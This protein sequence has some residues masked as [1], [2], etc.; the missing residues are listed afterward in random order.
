MLNDAKNALDNQ[1]YENAAQLFFTVIKTDPQNDLAH[2]GL[3]YALYKSNRLE[4][5]QQYCETAIELNPNLPMPYVILSYIN[6]KKREDFEKCYQLA[7]KAY[8]LAPDLPETLACFG[9][10]SLLL[11]KNEQAVKF[12]QRALSIS[13]SEWEIHNNLSIAYTRLNKFEEA[14][15]ETLVI[16]KLKPSL[17]MGIMLMLSFMAIDRVIK[18]SRVILFGSIFAALLLTS[19][20]LL[21]IPAIYAS[22]ML[23]GG[24]YA[25]MQK[26]TKAGIITI[27]LALVIYL[28]VFLLA[29]WLK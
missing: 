11:N 7:E 18:S 15:R 1:D 24:I 21:L 20:S 29:A 23:V 9:F 28:I 10:T 14:Y 25:L 4:E 27:L 12:L 3:G 8:A 2:Q 22:L 26:S 13:P 5:S 19:S 6:Y 16:Y 17:K